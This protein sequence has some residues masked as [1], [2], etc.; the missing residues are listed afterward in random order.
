MATDLMLLAGVV[1]AAVFFTVVV[2]EGARRRG[3]DPVYHTGSE[4]ELGERGWI[5]RANF[6][7]I[8]SGAF[9]FAVGV[10]RTLDSTAGAVLLAIFG[11]GLV[12]AGVFAPDPVRGYPPGAPTE[13]SAKPTWQAQVHAVVG[14]PIAF[15]AVFG[16]TLTLAGP[17]QGGWQLYTV[18]TAVAGLAM[19]VW[20]ALAFQK[21]AANT[22]LVQ[23]GLLLVYCSWIV[24][25][26]IHLVTDPPSL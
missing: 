18:F 25:L 10:Q 26:G 8:G 15:F 12:V 24:A 4:L 11:F 7:L 9:A 17:L 3:Y 20:T 16:A 23:R 1:T 19:T 14:G 6:F 5:Q 13:P 21:D 2:I 22:G